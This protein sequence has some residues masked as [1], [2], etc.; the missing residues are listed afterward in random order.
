[1]NKTVDDAVQIIE[2]IR[3]KLSP[4]AHVDVLVCPSFVCLEAAKRAIGV[5][6]IKL[7]AQNLHW[8]DAGAFTGEISA[9]ML[10]SVGVEYVII[11]HSERRQYFGETDETVNLRLKQA[12]VKGLKSIVCIGETLEERE[13]G[14]TFHVLKTQLSGGLSGI[15]A[16]Q[17]TVVVLAYEPVWAI[18]TGKVATNEQAQEAHAY[19]RTQLAVL[20]DRETADSVIIQY[21]GSVKP[22]NARELLLQPD[23]DGALVGRASLDAEDFTAIVAAA[24]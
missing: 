19:I 20:F 15:T 6:P 24:P 1:M 4:E 11:G 9:D 18:G 23:V 3:C 16:E 13:A 12:L 21:G 14:R 22:D 5:S 10:L 17:M 2:G 8:K 7:G